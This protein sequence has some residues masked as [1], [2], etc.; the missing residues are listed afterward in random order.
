[1]EASSLCA[2]SVGRHRQEEERVIYKRGGRRIRHHRLENRGGKKKKA[3][4]TESRL[5]HKFQ[6]KKDSVA[7]CPK[8]E[9]DKDKTLTLLVSW[10]AE[11][12]CLNDGRSILKTSQLNPFWLAAV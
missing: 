12:S 6:N 10:L 3:E 11:I 5:K 7:F 9:K 4:E 1:M 2:A 8:Q